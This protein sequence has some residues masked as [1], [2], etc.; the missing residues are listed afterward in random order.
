[1]IEVYIGGRSLASTRDASDPMDLSSEGPVLWIIAGW[2]YLSLQDD[3]SSNGTQWLDEVRQWGQT[4]RY[5]FLK[6]WLT[7]E[8]HQKKIDKQILRVFLDTSSIFKFHCRP[9]FNGFNPPNRWL[10]A[11]RVGWLS[12]TSVRF[13]PRGGASAHHGPPWPTQNEQIHY[14]TE[15]GFLAGY[16][17]LGGGFSIDRGMNWMNTEHPYSNQLY[18]GMRQGCSS[19]LN[20]GASYPQNAQVWCGSDQG[21]YPQTLIFMA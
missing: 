2:T 10:F 4:H 17:T 6:D 18:F 15:P 5:T 1:M 20:H 14:C 3:C 9:F 16:L 13:Q 7:Q 21:I 12:G 19:F 11:G 8:F